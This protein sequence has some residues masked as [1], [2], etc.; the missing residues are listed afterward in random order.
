MGK[1]KNNSGK[2]LNQQDEIKDK[3]R[4]VD[5]DIHLYRRVFHTAAASFLIYYSLPN[6]GFISVLK[7]YLPILIV[8]I[9]MLV[10]FF[11]IKG[12]H[13]NHFQSH[14]PVTTC[15]DNN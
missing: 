13:K 10:E 3:T 7:F 11:R 15:P 12:I 1:H 2:G 6:E 9:A 4:I 14:F 8:V 5:F